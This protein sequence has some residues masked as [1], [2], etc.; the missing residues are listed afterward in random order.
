MVQRTPKRSPGSPP[1][2][3]RGRVQNGILPLAAGFRP[4]K[5]GSRGVR[6]RPFDEESVMRFGRNSGRATVSSLISSPTLLKSCSVDPKTVPG[7][8]SRGPPGA[9]MKC[10]CASGRGF[11]APFAWFARCPLAH[12]R[13]RKCDAFRKE[14]C[15]RD[16]F[17]SESFP[18]FAQK[19]FSGPRNGPRDLL[20]RASGGVPE[21]G[22]GLWQGVFGPFCM[23]RAMS[24]YAPSIKKV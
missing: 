7:T 13:Y 14:F 17:V 10:T 15:N 21:N 3:P 22:F 5:H 24:A 18:N 11:S 2:G 6:L 9:W 16:R 8:P 19:L 1:G 4:E 20:L 23:V 12:V